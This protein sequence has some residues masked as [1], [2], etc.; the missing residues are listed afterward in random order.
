[1]IP[2]IAIISRLLCLQGTRGSFKYFPKNALL[3]FCLSMKSAVHVPYAGSSRFAGT[4]MLISVVC[5][6][7]APAVSQKLIFIHNAL[8]SDFTHFR[9]HLLVDFTYLQL[10]VWNSLR[11]GPSSFGNFFETQKN[12]PFVKFAQPFEKSHSSYSSIS[13]L[14]LLLHKGSACTGKDSCVSPF[15]LTSDSV[16]YDPFSPSH[17]FSLL[18]IPSFFAFVSPDPVHSFSTWDSNVLD[19]P[20][21]W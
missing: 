2:A 14:I 9:F 3:S 5:V 1:M 7:L 20:W 18:F 10:K 17:L 11:T 16:Q 21:H 8:H 12:I 15:S 13:S 4:S 6:F 19:T